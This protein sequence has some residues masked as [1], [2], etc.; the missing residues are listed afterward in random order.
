M[1]AKNPTATAEMVLP[2]S[3]LTVVVAP[4]AAVASVPREP[5]LAVSIYWTAVCKSCSSIVGHARVIIARSRALLL[6]GFLLFV[7]A[8]FSV[9]NISVSVCFMGTP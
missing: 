8:E 4:T 7:W 2:I 5:T 9:V 6:S 3:Q 1:N